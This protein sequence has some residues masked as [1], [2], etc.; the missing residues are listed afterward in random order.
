[1]TCTTLT[2]FK[3]I[4]FSGI[5]YSHVIVQTSLPYISRKFSSSQLKFIPVRQQ[6]IPPSPYPLILTILL[7]VF[8][9]E[10]VKVKVTQSCLT[11]CN[12]WAIQ[13]IEFSRPEY[14][15][16]QS[17]PYPGDPPN[18]GIEPKSPASQADS[19]PAEPQGKPK[20]TGVGSL[21][22]LIFLTQESNRGLLHCRQILYQLSY[23]GSPDTKHISILNPNSH[24]M[25]PVRTDP[26]SL[27]K[28]AHNIWE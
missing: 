7:S 8:M 12:P 10:K 1:M 26:L 14:W 19:L 9:K 5:K 16:G 23:Q 18:P 3:C 6:V 13:S 27:V 4:Q 28:T 15:S 20:N 11:L 22:Q 2:I 25:Y 24:H 17:F 21:L